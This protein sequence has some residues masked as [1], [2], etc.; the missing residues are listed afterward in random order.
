MEG[1]KDQ[2]ASS[3]SC[4]FL[5]PASLNSCWREVNGRIQGDGELRSLLMAKHRADGVPSKYPRSAR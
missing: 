5:Y 3:I 2:I 4:D 1:K